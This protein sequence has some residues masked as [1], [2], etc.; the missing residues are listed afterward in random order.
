MHTPL[1][2]SN[3]TAKSQLAFHVAKS[4]RG[5]LHYY[6]A[7]H[8]S[9]SKKGVHSIAAV[10]ATQGCVAHI[11]I[12]CGEPLSHCDQA[13]FAQNPSL[14]FALATLPCSLTKK[15]ARG[16]W[17]RETGQ[18][19][20]M[21]NELL[22]VFHSLKLDANTQKTTWHAIVRSPARCSSYV[23]VEAAGDFQFA[24]ENY[25]LLELNRRCERE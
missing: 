24:L 1:G 13:S 4:F 18:K 19:S 15:S 25:V 16:E 20:C 5:R 9:I 7:G 21:E 17:A 8:K 22:M 6:T 14:K 10:R 11:Y 12:Y 3:L 2:L 23:G